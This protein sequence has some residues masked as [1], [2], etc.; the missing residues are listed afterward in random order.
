MPNKKNHK[1]NRRRPNQ[2]R[3]RN[4][5]RQN[6]TEIRLF[7]TTTDIVLDVS[8]NVNV[9]YPLNSVEIQSAYI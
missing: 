6:R 4:P 2:P 5:H 7:T 9:A 3:A 1:R 8:G